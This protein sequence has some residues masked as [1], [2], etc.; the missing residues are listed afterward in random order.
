[1]KPVPLYRVSLVAM[2][3]IASLALFPA[4]SRSDP[5]GSCGCQAVREI[6]FETLIRQ[7]D[8]AWLVPT[9]RALR[10]PR[11]WEAAMDE[12]EA[13]H[14][15]VGREPVPD[16]DW[17]KNAVI[18]LALGT[19]VRE[20][21]VSVKKCTIEAELTVVDLHVDVPFQWDPIGTV[22]HPCLVVSVA[23]NDLKE[24]QLRFD[25]DIAGLPPGLSRRSIVANGN[26]HVNTA[27]SGVAA[28]G[29][30]V[31]SSWGQ[32]KALYR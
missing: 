7:N 29:G 15:I 1:M 27:S 20:C 26:N 22:E 21:R 23:R 5:P 4:P 24:L 28:A 17:T 25:A 18:V 10:S 2:F 19:Q 32:L 14:E 12:W 6:P 31:L 16:I 11:A 8:G 3:V 13:N 30:P 9:L